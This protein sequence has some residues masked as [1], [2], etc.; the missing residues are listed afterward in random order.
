M[1]A[2]RKTLDWTIAVNPHQ[3]SVLGPDVK[4]A[5]IRD[6]WS[7]INGFEHGKLLEDLE[8]SCLVLPARDDRSTP[9]M[10]FRDI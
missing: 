10:D 1:L 4:A 6:R 8:C 5:H 2:D 7:W 3:Q 9:L